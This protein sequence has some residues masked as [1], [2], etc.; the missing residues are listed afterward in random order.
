MS[1]IINSIG[2]I[3]R[4]I[5]LYLLLFFT[6]ALPFLLFGCILFLPIPEVDLSNKIILVLVCFAL[7][8]IN[9]KLVIV[10]DIF[11]FSHIFFRKKIFSYVDLE[12]IS[13]ILSILAAIIFLLIAI[14]YY[15]FSFG[16]L[17]LILLSFF[18]GKFIPNC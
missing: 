16:E 7:G 9:S 8:V 4:D 18:L 11:L 3:L 6:L 10:L 2:K 1:N 13:K 12:F 14:I 5:F 15:E 17:T